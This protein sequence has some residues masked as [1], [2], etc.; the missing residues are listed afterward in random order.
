MT[1]SKSGRILSGMNFKTKIG[2]RIH[3]T[4]RTHGMS[5]KVMY[6]DHVAA[7]IESSCF[8]TKSS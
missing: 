1:A 4:R 5:W 6:A 8:I 3:N 2:R 7:R